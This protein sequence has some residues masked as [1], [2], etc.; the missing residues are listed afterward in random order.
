M[1]D[2]YFEKEKIPKI[3]ADTLRSLSKLKPWRSISAIALDWLII[4]LCILMCEWIS[5]WLYPIAFV[6]VGS[7]FHGLEAMMHEATHYRLHPNKKMNELIGELSVW[8]LG[9][10][11]YFYRNVRHFA[12]HKRIGTMHDP[13]HVQ[14]YEKHPDRYDVPKS[15]PQLLK[16]CF[17][18]AIKA[19]VEIWFGQLYSTTRLLPQ[20]KRALGLLWISF[21]FLLL[22]SVVIGSI[23]ISPDI[24]KIYALFFILPL[25]WVAVFSR[26]ARLLTEHFGIPESKSSI[27]GSETRTI[28]VPWIVRVM[29]WPHNLNYHVEHHWYPSVPFYNLPVLH[30]ILIESPHARPQ[31]H[32]TR[33]VKNLVMEL[34]TIPT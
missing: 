6:L 18:V 26:Y 21:Q 11:I 25:A 33:G 3:D 30:K 16:S 19:P 23:L 13:H 34:T 12:H 14:S 17:I 27:T 2:I 31:M 32:I 28:L 7:R 8:P 1:D 22:A 24:V 29:F 15:L 9:L 20:F 10:S 4:I 5:Y